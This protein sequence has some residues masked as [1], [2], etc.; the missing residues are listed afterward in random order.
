MVGV[1]ED[2]CF[3]LLSAWVAM[4]GYLGGGYISVPFG[5]LDAAEGLG[6]E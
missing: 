3:I 6:G 1:L 4:E 5:R 2:S